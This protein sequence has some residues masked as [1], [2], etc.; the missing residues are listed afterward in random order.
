[1]QL[2]I[3]SLWV[4]NKPHTIVYV[5]IYVFICMYYVSDLKVQVQHRLLLLLLFRQL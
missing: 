4:S 5:H 3:I 1:M 2:A